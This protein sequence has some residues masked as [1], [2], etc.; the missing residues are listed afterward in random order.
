MLFA[1]GI[2]LSV[3]QTTQAHQE[4]VIHVD[5]LGLRNDKGQVLCALYSSADGFPT[6]SDKA[7]AHAKSAISAGRGACDFPG[8]APGTYALS[9][10]HDENANGKMDTNFIGIPREGVGASNNAKGHLGPPKFNAAAFQYIRGPQKVQITIT[11]L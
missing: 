4:N 7:Q 10:F 11:Y 6:K 9:V 8:I 2:S 5:I 1:C 3:A